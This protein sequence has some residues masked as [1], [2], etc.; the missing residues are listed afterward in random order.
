MFAQV[1]ILLNEYSTIKVSNFHSDDGTRSPLLFFI[2]NVLGTS[3]MPLLLLCTCFV[4]AKVLVFDLSNL[5]HELAALQILILFSD[6]ITHT[7][8]T[9][10]VF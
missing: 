10:R 3:L 7:I 6:S 4:I 9:L 5:M 1:N 2:L 8:L